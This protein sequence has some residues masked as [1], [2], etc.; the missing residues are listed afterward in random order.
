MSQLLASLGESNPTLLLTVSLV[1]PSVVMFTLVFITRK[2]TKASWRGH[3]DA[4]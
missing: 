1:A 4:L 3:W 2:L